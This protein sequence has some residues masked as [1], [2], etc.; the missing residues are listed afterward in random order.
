MQRVIVIGSLSWALVGCEED[1]ATTETNEACEGVVVEWEEPVIEVDTTFS[2][3]VRYSGD[4]RVT[5]GAMLTVEP[6]TRLELGGGS[7]IFVEDNGILHAVGTEGLPVTITSSSSVPAAGDWR[8]IDIKS[9]ADAATRFEHAIIEYGGG[10]GDAGA[11]VGTG[12]FDLANVTVR[13]APVDALNFRSGRVRQVTDLHVEDAGGHPIVVDLDGPAAMD[14]VTADRVGNPTI[15]MEADSALEVD[16]AWAPQSL[17]YEMRGSIGLRAD[18]TIE[19]GTDLWMTPGSR[20]LVQTSGKLDLLGTEAEPVI[21]QSASSSPLAGDWQHVNFDG[22]ADTSLWQWAV[23]MHG[24]GGGHGAANV[25]ADDRLQLEN[26]V[27]SDNQEC[28]IDAIIGTKRSVPAVNS[29]Y[30]LCDG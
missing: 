7:R 10:N 9:T 14:G 8:Y 11:I 15:L 30:V 17:P 24:G 23:I 21:V 6:G 20:I 3:T 16:A 5:G 28:D 19:A 22:D 12:S 1:P 29:P 25:E 18:L 27:F 26:V 2:C 13:H 4:L